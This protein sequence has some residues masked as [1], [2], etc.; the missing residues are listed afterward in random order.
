LEVADGG[1]L[2]LD[3]IGELP[4]PLQAKL[5]RVLEDQTFRRVGSAR[6]ISV[7]LRIVGAT[8][9]NLEKA[10]E[11]RRFRIDLYY[12]LNGV[13]IRLPALRERPDDIADLAVHFLSHFNRIHIRDLRGIHPSA[14][15]LLE[16]YRWP[17]N[18]RE[19]R[20]VIERA[21]LV[22]TSPL[23]T[24]ESLALPGRRGIP[25][26]DNAEAGGGLLSA[27]FSLRTGEQE[28]IAAALAECR[29]NQ[30]RAAELL[31]IGRFSLRYKMK[32]LGML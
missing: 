31:G 9:S 18:A 14:Q 1:T 23:I 29:G 11:E 30:T 3:E 27:R 6:D 7:N 10:I 4:P 28:L 25:E 15:R 24:P 12:R 32:R 2:F 17:G 13:Q 22:E 5:L 16:T 20:N 19:L 26:A 8:N 21:V